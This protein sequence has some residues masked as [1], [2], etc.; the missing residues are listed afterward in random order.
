ML[1]NASQLDIV[2]ENRRIYNTSSLYLLITFLRMGLKRR[3]LTFKCFFFKK[4]A[5]PGIRCKLSRDDVINCS[6]I[7]I[8]M[9]GE[10]NTVKHT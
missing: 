4:K 1:T 6:M 10:V 8:R 3:N 7:H 2:H 5:E 9:K